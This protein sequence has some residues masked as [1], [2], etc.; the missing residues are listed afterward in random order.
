MRARSYTLGTCMQAPSK[1]ILAW[2]RRAYQRNRADVLNEGQ[3]RDMDR[4]QCMLKNVIVGT[5]KMAPIDDQLSNGSAKHPIQAAGSYLLQDTAPA[6]V[7]SMMM[8]H[9]TVSSV[10]INNNMPFPVLLFQSGH[11]R[12]ILLPMIENRHVK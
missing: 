7:V 10:V 8:M 2:M 3:K 11:T 9:H 12:V 1:T 4:K 6:F 5:C